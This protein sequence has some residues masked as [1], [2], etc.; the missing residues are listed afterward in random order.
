MYGRYG[1]AERKAMVIQYPRLLL[2]TVLMAIDYVRLRLRSR[3][4]PRVPSG[5]AVRS[6]EFQS[7]CSGT[8]SCKKMLNVGKVFGAE[9]LPWQD[10]VPSHRS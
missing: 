2:I 7:P 5:S 10:G 9:P 3:P 6:T 1:L 8:G 4:C